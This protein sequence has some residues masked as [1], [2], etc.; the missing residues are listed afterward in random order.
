MVMIIANL[1]SATSRET[2]Q[3]HF[4]P[5]TMKPRWNRMVFKHLRT[6]EDEKFM[7]QCEDPTNCMTIYVHCL[8]PL[9]AYESVVNS[10]RDCRPRGQGFKSPP[11]FGF[12]CPI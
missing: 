6:R 7:V 11:D 5:N 1:Y 3:R 8:L 2:H 4:R 12:T 10:I 9:G